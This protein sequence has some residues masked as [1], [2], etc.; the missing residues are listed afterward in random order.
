MKISDEIGHNLKYINLSNFKIKDISFLKDLPNLETA[1][2]SSNNITKLNDLEKCPSIK[3]LDLN[4]NSV[5]SLIGLSGLKE[6]TYLDV[7]H[8]EIQTVESLKLL[9]LNA[10]LQEVNVLFNPFRD[11]K[12]AEG[13]VI[14][15]GRAL[16]R[17]NHVDVTKMIGS[18]EEKNLKEINEAVIQRYLMGHNKM[19]EVNGL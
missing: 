17:V 2:L 7:S 14:K 6:L 18:G 5:E 11:P 19:F 1:L 9:E 13:V 15:L 10:K 12:E 16:R 4:H 8:N 3:V